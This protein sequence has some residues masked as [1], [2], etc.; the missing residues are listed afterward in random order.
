MRIKELS[1]MSS[2]FAIA[3]VFSFF[4][5]VVAVVFYVLKSIALQTLAA[6][7]G[8]ENPWLGWI[9]IADLYIMGLLVK[10]MDVFGYHLDNLG[11]WCPVI[12]VG[13][14]ILANIP[15]LGVIISVALLV[16]AVLFTYRLFEIYTSQAI[17][18]TVLSVLLCLFPVF[19]FIIRNNDP[20]DSNPQGLQPPTSY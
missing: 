14:A 5:F 11:L 3:G 17:L 16:F 20:I 13:G 6:K 12:F 8:I 15:V 10:E 4:F 19:L 1:S 9:P 7:R 18:Y 2:V